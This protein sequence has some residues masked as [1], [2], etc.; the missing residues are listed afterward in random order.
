MDALRRLLVEQ[1]GAQ[2]LTIHCRTRSQGHAGDADWEWLSK[3]KKVVSIPVIGNGDVQTP[4]DAKAM[5]ETGCDGVMIG[6]GAIGNPWIFKQIQDVLAKK[7]PIEITLA[8]RIQMV[9]KH[10]IVHLAQ[11]G[12]SAVPAFRK[13]ISWYFKGLTD[14][15]L[16]R[17]KL[18]SA[19]TALELNDVLLAID[20]KTHS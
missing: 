6:R 14:F 12:E 13:H 20:I 5:L 11:Y 7:P 10:L 9:Q 15:K 19:R 3:I 8:Q 18:M 2:A 17:E 1:A 16:Y 4:P